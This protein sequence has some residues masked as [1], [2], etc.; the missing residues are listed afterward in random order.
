[1]KQKITFQNSKGDNIVGILSNLSE[2]VDVP[3]IVLCH[4]FSSGKDSPT[5]VD[6]EEQLNSKGVATFRFDFYGHG[7]SDGEF[8]DI[9]ISE[10]VDDALKAIE[11]VKG[12]GFSKV[13]LFGS[14]FGGITTL[15]VAS[16]VDDLLVL[17]LKAPVSDYY[18]F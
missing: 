9:T 3:I 13:G 17:G 10:A 18:K 2:N 12:K 11:F 6:L 7:E 14:S 5:Y 8:E 16:Q 4:G 15:M 1:M